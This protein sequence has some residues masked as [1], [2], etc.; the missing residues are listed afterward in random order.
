MN[1]SSSGDKENLERAL[2]NLFTSSGEG[3]Y[4]IGERYSNSKDSLKTLHS[5]ALS[6][7]QESTPDV[8]IKNLISNEGDIRG[9]LA[10]MWVVRIVGDKPNINRKRSVEFSEEIMNR[11]GELVVKSIPNQNGDI[12]T[13]EGNYTA[14]EHMF[15]VADKYTEIENQARKSGEHLKRV[16]AT[17]AFVKAIKITSIIDIFNGDDP[18]DNTFNWVCKNLID[19]ELKNISATFKYE[20]SDDILDVITFTIVP[21]IK[22]ILNN[23]Y[24]DLKKVPRKEWRERG[25]FT[26]SNLIQCLKNH[27]VIRDFNSKKGNANFNHGIDVIVNYMV[28]NNLL[29]EVSKEK[30]KSFVSG[31][32]NFGNGYMITSE[33]EASI[34]NTDPPK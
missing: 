3:N 4:I 26:K 16:M 1:G 34:S 10:R 8:F 24:N 22:R 15:D 13:L 9:D 32:G 14:S 19:T 27:K 33:L 6:L 18:S 28:N 29:Y 5:P 7:L 25:V 12:I 23:G 17:R 2:L 31:G 21:T 20:S 11:I 30:M